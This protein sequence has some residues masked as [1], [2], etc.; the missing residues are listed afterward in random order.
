MPT[1]SNGITYPTSSG[2]TRIWEHF[3]T[4]AEDVDG[5]IDTILNPPVAHLRQT[6]A[7][8]LSSGSWT[9][10]IFQSEDIDTHNGHLT[11]VSDNQRRYTAQVAGI[12]EFS[13]AATFTTAIGGNRW[14][15]WAKNGTEIGGSG[16]NTP[17]ISGGQTLLTARTVNVFLNVGD[18]VE[19]FAYQDSGNPVDTYVGVT[20]AQ[21]SMSV[22]WIGA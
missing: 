9:A 15:R 13:G 6:T 12:Y 16:A 14:C 7:Q 19:L 11:G 10:L 2:H 1:T 8:T 4:L 22:K 18:Y 5:L 21:S 17:P 20:Y 3:Q